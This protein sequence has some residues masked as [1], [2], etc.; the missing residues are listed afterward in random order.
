MYRV[1]VKQLV[2]SSLNLTFY[3]K[4]QTRNNFQDKPAYQLLLLTS[5]QMPSS[6][7]HDAY[8]GASSRLQKVKRLKTKGQEQKA[9]YAPEWHKHH[10]NPDRDIHGEKK[11]ARS[12][13]RDEKRK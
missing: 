13:K 7:R 6:K 11:Q 10:L 3:P 12:K 8:E 1:E 4:S 9:E 2:S 5:F